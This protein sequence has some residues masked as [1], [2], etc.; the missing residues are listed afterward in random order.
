MHCENVHAAPNPRAPQHVNQ[1]G[2]LVATGRLAKFRAWLDR[3]DGRFYRI[4]N[5]SIGGLT[6]MGGLSIVA[7]WVPW[8]LHRHVDM[9]LAWPIAVGAAGAAFL[10]LGARSRGRSD[11]S[12]RF[13]RAHIASA[14]DVIRPHTSSDLR[15]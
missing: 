10:S 15:R 3:D 1:A 2:P 11:G 12:C 14:H 7:S 4:G 13:I 8:Q 6:T 9:H 5:E